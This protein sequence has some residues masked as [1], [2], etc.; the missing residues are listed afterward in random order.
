VYPNTVLTVGDQLTASRRSW[1]AYVGD[2]SNGAGAPAS[3][4]HPESGGT[5]DTL[6]ERPGDGYAT[7]LNPFVYF[8]SLLDLGD[9]E[10]DDLPLTQLDDDLAR[11]STT[12]SYAFI[13]PNLCESGAVAPCLDGRPGGLPTVDAFLAREVPAILAS[14]A[15]RQ[16]GVLVIAFVSRT[17]AARAAGDTEPT[18][19]LVL[20]RFARAGA[21]VGRRYD[22]YSL[23]RSLEDVFAV[24]PLGFA[25]QAPSFARPVLAKAFS[26]SSG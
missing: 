20:S 9:C 12:P 1:R 19:A 11:A 5:D 3:C 6:T 4:R 24:D 26:P 10:A 22:P 8:H 2:L 25:A 21:T 18:G 14:P 7:R 23:L 16:D 13:A 17:A 15:Y